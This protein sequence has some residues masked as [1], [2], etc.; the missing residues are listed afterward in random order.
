MSAAFTRPH[1]NNTVP[2]YTGMLY[3]EI[4][5]YACINTLSRRTTGDKL[6]QSVHLN[7]VRSN[8]QGVVNLLGTSVEFWKKS[9][10]TVNVYFE[11]W[12]AF[13][14]VMNN[15]NGDVRTNSI[16]SIY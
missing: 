1:S 11:V 7:F 16:Y 4:K 3:L 10:L 8:R 12:K 15:R 5:Q 13:R 6:V 2:N 9:D 14:S